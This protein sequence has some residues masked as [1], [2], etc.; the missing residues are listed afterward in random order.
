MNLNIKEISGEWKEYTLVNDSGMSVSVLDY[1]GIMTKIMV[2]DRNGNLENVVLG[3]KDYLDYESN[4]NYFG[5]LIGRVAGRIQG[6]SF[7]LDGKTIQLAANNGNNHL[8]GGPSGFHR[9]IW[10]VKPFQTDDTVGLELIHRS[11][12][13]AGGYPGNV[14][15]TVTYSLNNKNQLILN[16][17]ASS[18]QTTPITLT[19]HSYFNLSGNLTNTVQDHH[20][21]LDSSQFVE[22]DNDLIP[23]GKLIHVAGSSF[24]FR[25]GRVLGDGFSSDSYQNKV[26]GSGY[27]HYFIF[28]N[29]MENQAIIHDPASGRVMSIKTNQPG[30]VMYTA[31]SLNEE[32]QLAEG[33][34]RKYLGVCFETQAS[35]ASLH[36]EGFPSVMLNAG[37][38]YV[39]Q[40]VF[41]FRV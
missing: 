25:S 17:M 3:Y 34:S 13:G 12:D 33:S 28:E 31:N 29:T 19:N 22:L 30:M 38:N 27:D 26:A 11:V 37:E 8:H 36:H 15:I 14:D 9:V 1:G 20:V 6:A 21:T 7:E 40:T 16:Y 2:P 10:D 32:L 23:T 4:S 5:A 35:P 41:S 39:K 24:D 18:D